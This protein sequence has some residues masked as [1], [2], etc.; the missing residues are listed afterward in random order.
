MFLLLGEFN[1]N[2]TEEQQACVKFYFKLQK[3]ATKM[4]QLLQPAYGKH[5]VLDVF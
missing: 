5:S 3:T 2:L 1:M 4:L